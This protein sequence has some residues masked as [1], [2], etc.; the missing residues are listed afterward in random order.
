MDN[1]R[2]KNKEKLYQIEMEKRQIEMNQM[3]DMNFGNSQQNQMQF[4][5]MMM[6]MNNMYGGNSNKILYNE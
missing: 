1:I 4:M 3:Q 2:E 5:N 6:G